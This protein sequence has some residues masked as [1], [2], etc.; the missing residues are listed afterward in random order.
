MKTP[1]GLEESPLSGSSSSG[2]RPS[3]GSREVLV[4]EDN[5]LMLRVLESGLRDAGFHLTAEQDPHAALEL[6]RAFPFRFGVL[7]TD[8]VMPKMS[9]LELAERVRAL[10]P[11]IAIVLHSAKEDASDPRVDVIV[12]K[13]ATVETLATALTFLLDVPD[14]C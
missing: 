3:G 13:P 5:R 14:A 6:I 7:L 9:G 1:R 2:V 10:D 8:L 12:P 4:V 11:R